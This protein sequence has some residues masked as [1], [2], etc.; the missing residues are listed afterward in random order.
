LGDLDGG[1]I[2]TVRDRTAI[3]NAAEA[4]FTFK[5]HPEEAVILLH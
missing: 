3:Y 4:I 2:D 1:K 5:S